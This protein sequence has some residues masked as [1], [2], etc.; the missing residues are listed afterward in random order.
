ML[1]ALP[2]GKRV[3]PLVSELHSNSVEAFLKLLPKGSGIQSRSLL[4]WG[5]VRVAVDEQSAKPFLR[6]RFADLTNKLGCILNTNSVVAN[7]VEQKDDVVVEKVALWVPREPLDFLERAVQVGHP[8]SHSI[9]LPRELEKVV[10]YNRDGHAFDLHSGRIEFVKKWSARAVELGNADDALLKDAPPYLKKLLSTKR[11]ALWKEMLDFYQ[12]PDIELLDNLCNGFPLLGWVPKSNVFPGDLRTPSLD[13]EVLKKMSKGLNA[14]VKAKVLGDNDPGI[15]AATWEETCEELDGGWMSLDSSCD[16][17][18]AWAM[19][20]GLQ[21]K[22]KVRV[23]DDFTIAGVNQCVGWEGE[24]KIFGIDDI[25]ALI[26]H[27]LDSSSSS[28]HPA[29]KGK[30]IDLRHA[31]KEFGICERDR[32]RVRV[33]TVDA[34]TRELVTLLVNPLPFSATGSVSAFLRVSMSIWYLGVVGLGLA[35]TCYY[36]DYTL[37]SQADCCKVT[38][39]A[40]ESLL[41]LLRSRFCQRW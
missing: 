31:Y 18:A 23:I 9:S 17:E 41:N 1:G 13:A 15:E 24:L 33:A 12:Y 28:Q 29:F 7:E 11:L 40:V 26:A 37:L 27:S 10:D 38:E 36:D 21:Q 14:R 16:E 6:E 25:A 20:F 2:R 4:K 35:W 8:R 3:A 22:E 39:W 34:N 32:S 30:T 5:V 19:R